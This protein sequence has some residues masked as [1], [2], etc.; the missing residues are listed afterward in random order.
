MITICGLKV[1]VKEALNSSLYYSIEFEILKYWHSWIRN[2]IF[3]TKHNDLDFC[4]QRSP[5]DKKLLWQRTW[6]LTQIKLF[7]RYQKGE[8]IAKGNEITLYKS[9]TNCY[10]KKK[11]SQSANDASQG[12]IHVNIPSNFT[13]IVKYKAHF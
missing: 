12:S 2:F 13:G 4:Y 6:S 8:S 3:W 7:Y 1:S 11:D 10:S 5:R 9:T